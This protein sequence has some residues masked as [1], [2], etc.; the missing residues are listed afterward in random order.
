[1]FKPAIQCPAGILLNTDNTESFTII[2]FHLN[3]IQL[4]ACVKANG[5]VVIL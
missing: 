2:F 3:I 4:S 1:M 5:F